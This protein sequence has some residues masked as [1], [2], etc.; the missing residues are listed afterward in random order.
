MSFL[1]A[2]QPQSLTQEGRT[3]PAEIYISETIYQRELR[4]I[5][6]RAWCYVGHVS[7]LQGPGSYFTLDLAEQPL[8]IVQNQAGALRGF[9]NICPHRAVP[10]VLGSGQCD[11]LSCRYHTLS[12]DLEGQLHESEGEQIEANPAEYPLRPI[13]VE[14][15]GPFIFVNLDLQAGPLADQLGELPEKFQRYRFDEWARIHSVDYW[16]E[17]NWKLYVEN[18]VE[19]YHEFSV[20]ASIAR[21]YQATQAEA[22]HHYYLQ[23]AAFPPDDPDYAA[24]PPELIFPGLGEPERTGKSTVS[25]F[26]NFAWIVRPWI[27]IIYLIDPQGRSRTRIRWDWLVPDSPTARAADNV[28]PLIEFFD[29]IQQEDLNLLPAIQRRIESSGYRPGRL[30]PTREVGTHLFQELVMRYLTRPD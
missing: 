17:T 27:A 26:P 11:R 7:Q 2:W 23:Y 20:H 10:V 29:N 5:F 28:Q 1:T 19:S 22:R 13:Q 4:Q 15:W 25:L 6:G 3:F 12:F 30:S 24:K 9:F 16:T 18:N 14:T 21:Y 8:V